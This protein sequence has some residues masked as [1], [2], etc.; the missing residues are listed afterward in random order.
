M[1]GRGVKNRLSNG[2]AGSYFAIENKVPNPASP[3]ASPPLPSIAGT[4][5]TNGASQLRSPALASGW[6][7]RSANSGWLRRSGL[8]AQAASA[9]AGYFPV[10]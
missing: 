9:G 6:S 3:S 5:K 7:A 2:Q 1:S 10:R 8:P 4:A